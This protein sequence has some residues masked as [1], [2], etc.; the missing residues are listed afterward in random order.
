MVLFC[1]SLITNEIGHLFIC[2][3]AI[4]VFC[5]RPIHAFQLISLW[6]LC[7]IHLETFSIDSGQ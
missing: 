6:V 7:L 5:E 1:I 2:L 3:L 4:Y